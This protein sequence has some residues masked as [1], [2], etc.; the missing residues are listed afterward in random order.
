MPEPQS[1]NTMFHHS[2]TNVGGDDYAMRTALT[3]TASN[4]LPVTQFPLKANSILD[5][6]AVFEPGPNTI[7]AGFTAAE[8]PAGYYEVH[9]TWGTL[10]IAGGGEPTFADITNFGSFVDAVKVDDLVSLNGVA[11]T[12]DG[13]FN[14]GGFDFSIRTKIAGTAN[15][16]YVALIVATLI[17]N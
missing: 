6:R 7:L 5:T 16:C 14:F 3:A 13:Y 17:D 2:F 10:K 9:A 1:T 11:A 12:I 15:V 4:P 8:L